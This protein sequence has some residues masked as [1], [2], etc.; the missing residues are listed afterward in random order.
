MWSVYQRSRGLP[1]RSA[2]P[3][4]RAERP[5]GAG[6]LGERGDGPYVALGFVPLP[7][8]VSTYNYGTVTSDVASAD[9][10]CVLQP[11]TI[12]VTLPENMCKPTRT[13][14]LRAEQRGHVGRER[15]R[16]GPEPPRTQSSE[17]RAQDRATALNRRPDRTAS[18]GEDA[19]SRLTSQEHAE[20]QG[21]FQT[22]FIP[23]ARP[24]SCPRRSRLRLPLA[25][26]QARA[27]RPSPRVAASENRP[28]PAARKLLSKNKH[29]FRNLRTG[30]TRWQLTH[31]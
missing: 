4:T 30:R 25:H 15:L 22:C 1:P 9:L 10:R 27:P 24:P 28:R 13:A 29:P 12:Q 31:Q 5:L 23:A 6:R 20:W 26:S 17:D 19:R 8:P 21:A 14:G 18:V 11:E 3:R 2:G 7:C 16:S